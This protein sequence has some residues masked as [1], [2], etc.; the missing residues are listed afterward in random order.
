VQ[1]IVAAG[2]PEDQKPLTH[3]ASEPKQSTR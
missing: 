3:D 1:G 2:L